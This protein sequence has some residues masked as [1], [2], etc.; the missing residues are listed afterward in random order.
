[1]TSSNSVRRAVRQSLLIS[2]MTGAA[3]AS[4]PA[5]AQDAVL[6]KVVVTGSRIQQANL[7]SISPVTAVG[8]EEIKLEGVTRVEDLLNNLPQVF[9]DFGGNLSNGATGAA[10][11][12][13]R[14]LGAQR[15]LVLVNGRRLMPGDPTQN[16]NATADLNQI[17]AALV[18]RVD[19]LTGGASAVYGADAVAG[20]VNFIMNDHF[21]GVRVDANYGFYQHRQQNDFVQGRLDA[22]NF[23][24][25][26][27]SVR[28]GY[29][30]D[31]T[32]ILGGNFADGKGNATVYLGYRQLTTIAQDQRDFS[33]CSLS[34]GAAFACAGSSTSADGRF[35]GNDFVP[36]DPL[37]PDDVAGGFGFGGDYTVGAG[38]IVPSTGAN[39]YNFAPTNYYQRPDERYTAGLMAH[40]DFNDN[41]TAY[42]EFSFMTDRTVAQIAP[43]GA[44]LG[45][46]IATDPLTGGIDGNWSVNCDNPYL[47]ATGDAAVFCD[48][49]SYTDPVTGALVPYVNADN[50]TQVTFGRRNVEGGPRR[51]DL[52]HTSYRGVMGL[53]GDIND[54]WKYDVYGLF[55]RTLFAENYQ[56]DVSKARMQNALL[57]ANDPLTGTVQCLA[58]INGANGAPGCVPYNIW[59]PGGVTPE[60]V[61]YFTVPGFQQGSTTE[62]VLSGAVTGDLTG[63]GIKLPSATSGLSVAFGAEYRS[64]QSELRPDIEFITNDLAGQGAPTL[65]L[66]ASFYVKEVF[67]EF[68]LPLV[69]DK[70]GAESLSVEGAYRYSDYSLGFNTSTYKLGVEWAPIRD[71]RVRG[72]YQRAVRAPNLQ[73]LYLQPRVQNDGSTDPCAGAAPAATLIQCAR[74]GVTAGQYGSIIENPAAQYN[75]YVAGNANLKPEESDT[76]TFGLVVQPSILPGFSLTLDYFDITVDEVINSLGADYIIAQCLASG[77]PTYCSLVKRAPNGSLWL[78]QGGY[79][80]DT[81]NNLGS[82]STRGV[83]LSADYKLDMAAA[84]SLAFSLTGTYMLDFIT[85]PTKGDSEYD[86]V[87]LYGS[88]CGT[89]LNEW[90]HKFRITWDTPVEGLSLSANWRHIAEVKL[91]H[92]DSNPSLSGAVP[93]TDAKLGARNYLDLSGSYAVTDKIVARAGINNVMDKDPPLLGADNLPGVYGSG[94]TFPQVYDTLGREVFMNLTIDF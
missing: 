3:V 73:E 47:V 19:V 92:T 88:I 66:D 44:F 50:I 78:S 22:R 52:I 26:E 51:D 31:I 90:R 4:A 34:S 43:S 40:Y 60:A 27:S 17:P 36:E 79:I 57:A 63:Y 41:A 53:R 45:S 25:P 6:D 61:A 77:A 54:D 59:Q 28:D 24:K 94:N 74:T 46:G 1:M 37:D 42:T 75:G 14:N 38:G 56:N 30:K 68:R 9:A 21:E 67:T 82:L 8:A 89:P 18:E 11:V 93:A 80:I 20:V 2:A 83:D 29:S 71:V 39:R 49:G 65:P 33:A 13:L 72:S 87:G 64:E 32:A 70:P 12:N 76:I 35:F 55:G 91:D 81:T 48:P 86:C 7:E 15:T 69:Q 16:G 62:Q 85:L 10:T 84:G 23:A 58:N 5:S